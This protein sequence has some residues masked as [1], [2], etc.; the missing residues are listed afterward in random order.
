[1][2]LR[3]RG[4][5]LYKCPYFGKMKLASTGYFVCMNLQ[6]CGSIETTGLKAWRPMHCIP[7]I[8]NNKTNRE[9]YTKWE[10]ET[11][12]RAK[13]IDREIERERGREKYR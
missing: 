4:I 11:K 9:K 13:A 10:R 2:E 1:M 3:T 12:K 7:L 5:Q 6:N 8:Q